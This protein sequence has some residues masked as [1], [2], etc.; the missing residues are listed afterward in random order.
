MSVNQMLYKQ[1]FLYA[2]SLSLSL[3]K[4]VVGLR[5]VSVNELCVSLMSSVFAERAAPPGQS[6]TVPEL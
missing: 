5:A 6:L 2:Q 3:S 4:C 1:Y